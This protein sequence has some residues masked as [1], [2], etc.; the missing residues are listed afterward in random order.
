MS[1]TANVPFHVDNGRDVAGEINGEALNA[2]GHL[3]NNRGEEM[4]ILILPGLL[5]AMQET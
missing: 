3:L 1:E 5:S 2:L 4:E